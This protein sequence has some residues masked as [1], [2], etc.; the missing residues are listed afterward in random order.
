MKRIKMLAAVFAAKLKSLFNARVAFSATVLNSQVDK[1]A[2]L[3]QQTRIHNCRVGRYT[4]IARNTLAQRVDFGDFCS[5]SEG[6]NIGMPSHPT[7]FVSTSPVFLQGGNYLK[8]HFAALPYENCPTTTVGN[9]VWIG[10]HA[11]VK[12]GLTI[13]NGAIIAAGAVV[14]HDVPPYAIVGG[15]PA[16]VIRYRFDE[17]TIHRL[18]AIRWWDSTDAQLTKT[19]PLVG[20]MQAFLTACEEGEKL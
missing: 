8:K 10:A 4:Y 20:D 12:S 17:E 7:E 19:G 15:V 11:Q 9:D 3:R 14:T 16:K 18:E 5:V 2:A 1:T 6:C 13:G